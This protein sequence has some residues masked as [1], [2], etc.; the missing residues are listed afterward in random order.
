MFAHGFSFEIYLVSVVYEAVEDGIGQGGIA[1]DV[2]PF[3]DGKL[4]GDQG[5]S[6]GWRIV[7]QAATG[8]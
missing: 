2:V 6:C 7:V 3:F 1:D 8:N 4:T 5:R